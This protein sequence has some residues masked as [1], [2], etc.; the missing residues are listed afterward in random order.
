MKKYIFEQ[1]W[2][3]VFVVIVNI[4]V[5][6]MS[7]YI[8]IILRDALDVALNMDMSGFRGVMIVSA[9][10]FPV[11]TIFYYLSQALNIKLVGKIAINIRKDIFKGIMKKSIT[12]FNSVNSA[13]YIS[14]L[15]NDIDLLRVLL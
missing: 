11:F 4:I 15:T 8:A 14:A 1:K 3:L 5:A 10:F 6:A 12:E 2:I 13:D 9:I 7:V